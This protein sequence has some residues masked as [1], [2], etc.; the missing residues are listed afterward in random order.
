MNI[1][2]KKTIKF[3]FLSTFTL[4]AFSA[5]SEDELDP[6]SIFVD[7]EIALTP[8]EK[9][10]ER[11]YTKPYNI[12]I[13]YKYVDI[14]SN[15]NYNL[16]PATYDASV[17]MTKLM[18]YLAIEPYD[19]VTGSKVF[20]RNY[21]PKILNYVGSPAYNNNGT[22]VLGT[23][24]GGRKI[25]LFNLNALTPA[26]AV[27]KDYLLN[28]YFRTI[29]HEFAHIFHQTKPYSASFKQISGTDYVQ[30]QWNVEFNNTTA[31]QA[32]FISPY[33]SK[34]ANEDFVELISFYILLTEAE[35]NARMTTAGANGRAIINEKFDIVR[36]YMDVSWGIDLDELR[37]NIQ[38]RLDNLASFDQTTID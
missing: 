37:D 19:E 36:N 31:L 17:R 4:L 22:M 10:I 29:H 34:D 25:T 35:W 13:L 18:Q 20:I 14:E 11:E 16:S 21:F 30:D 23:A 7:S 28:M 32:G 24:E 8:L 3:L 2:M 33:A 9:Y 6:N 1:K 26:R 15:M 27:D 5:C 38:G 12:S